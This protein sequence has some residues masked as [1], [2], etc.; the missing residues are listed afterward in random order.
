MTAT[1]DGRQAQRIAA[2]RRFNRFYT[3][4]LGVLQDGWLGS[5]FSLTEARVLYEIRHRGRTTA[6]EI[7][8]ELALDAGYLSRILRRFHRARLISKVVSTDDGRQS[9]LAMTA[10]GRSAFDPLEARTERQIGALL[11]R[12]TAPERDRLVSAMATIEIMTGAGPRTESGIILRQPRPGD[13]GWVVARHAELYAQEYDWGENF[14]GL[15][16][17]IVADFARKYDPQRE[18]CWIAELDGRN[19]G[20]VFLVKDSER[21]ARLRL[22]LVDPVARGHGLGTRLTNECVSFARECGYQG[23]TL[24]THKVLIA[25]RIVY[26]RAGFRLRSSERRR[27][28]GKDVISEH[29][30]LALRPPPHASRETMSARPSANN[31]RSRPRAAGRRTP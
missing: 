22:L 19:V 28:F 15:C 27:S 17:Q 12:L 21:I 25:A 7:A 26:Q 11:G 14:E 30:D 24:W 18:R 16:A 10:R 4:K 1:P 5:P 29:W 23:I 31:G 2:V 20:S 3:Q 13:L 8:R 6:S 9:R